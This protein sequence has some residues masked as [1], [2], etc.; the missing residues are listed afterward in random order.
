MNYTEFFR[1]VRDKT[2]DELDA[3]SPKVLSELM[4]RH[5]LAG[6][7]KI[8]GLFPEAR[9]DIRGRLA[10]L[11][12]LAY[13]ETSG[14]TVDLPLPAEFEPALEAYVVAAIYGSDAED[15]KDESLFR[16][17]DKRFKELTGEA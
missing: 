12:A 8:L 7:R 9:L 2:K 5:T 17:W 10:P 1:Q 15:I 11:P 6:L 13:N 4:G 16:Y 3:A 14:A